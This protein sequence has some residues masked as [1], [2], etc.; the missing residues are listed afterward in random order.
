MSSELTLWTRG[1]SDLGE[2]ARAY[3]SH[4]AAEDLSTVDDDER[5]AR[6]EAHLQLSSDRTGEQPAVRVAEVDGRSIAMVVTEDM[7]HLV[8]SVSGEVSRQGHAMSMVVHPIFLIG[9]SAEEERRL[10]SV[11]RVAADQR[12]LASGD[13]QTMPDLAELLE[14]EHRTVVE[15]WIAVELDHPID[16]EQ[17]GS[18][19]EGLHAVLADVAVS[20][21]D[22]DR[23]RSRARGT[24]GN[25]RETE[26]L[27]EGPEA[28]DL[29][30]WMSD[31]HFLFLG[32][33]EYQFDVPGDPTSQLS[34]VTAGGLGILAPGRDDHLTRLHD[35][36]GDHLGSDSLDDDR[37]PMAITKA[38]AHSTVRRRT[39]MDYVAVKT[40]SS[41]GSVRG[42]R[43]FVGLFNE[44][45]YTQ[46]I[47][48]IPLLRSRAHELLRRSGFT[49]DSHSGS[50]LMQILETYPRDEL[51]QMG[52]DEIEAAA[53]QVL[54]LQERRRIRLILRRD[55][56]G[57]F[58]TALLYMPRDRY[59]TAVRR[60]VEDTLMRHID[61]ESI[62]F[63]VRLTESVLARVFF[64]MRL[65]EG[66]GEPE[67]THEELE[68]RL[69]D[70]I[71][72]WPD[73]VAGQ[74]EARYEESRAPQVAARW[75]EA[76]PA[77]YRVIYELDEAMDDIAEFESLLGEPQAGP[78][79]RFCSPGAD[80]GADMRLKLYL[81]EPKTLT[82]TLPVLDAFGL[83][84]LDERSYTLTLGG[85]EGSLHLYDLGL[86]YPE[87]VDAE[88]T[89]PL[90][91]EAY[92]AVLAGRAESDIFSSLVLHLGL[93][94]RK[95]TVLRA[96][97]G[98]MRQLGITHSY[99][100]I[101]EALRQNAPVASALVEYF[102]ARFD[103]KPDGEPIDEEDRDRRM[104]EARD[105][106]ESAMESVRTL[107]ADRVLSLY[108]NLIDSTQRTNAY[109][110]RPWLA[111]K[112]TPPT[113]DA[114]P[115]P[116]P[117]HEIYVYS[118]QVEGV[119]LR[120][121]K[122]ARGGLRWSDRPED[123]RTE[124][125]GLVK[126]QMVKNSVIVPSG[127]K[128]GFFAKQLP[129]P[130]ADRGAWF[131]AGR[132]AYKVFIRALLD[133]TDNQQERDGEMVVT[134]PDDVIRH[135]GDDPY[136]VVAA[137]KGTATFSDTANEL[138][139]E[140][141][142]WLGDAFASG[143]SVGYDHKAMGITARGAWESV[144]SHFSELGIDC[145]S[146]EFT[147]VAVGDMAGDV[148][149]NGMLRSEHTLLVGAFNH[150]HIFVDPNPDAAASFEERS[151][152]FAADQSGWDAYDTSLISEGGGVFS[153]SDKTVRVTPQMRE[154]FDIDGSVSSMT[155][156]EL[157][158]AMLRAPSD[159]LYNGGIGTY[160]KGS[161]ETHESVGDRA[162]NAVRVDGRDVRAR[163]I[164]E[165][166]NLGM[167]Q[168][169]RIEAAQA[170]TLLNT[171]AIDN[172]AGV[173]C[174]D[175]EVN[176]KILVDQLI[177]SGHFDADDRAQLLRDMTDDVAE[178]V[179]RNNRDQNVLLLTDRHRMGDWSPSFQRLMVWLEEVA[180]LDRRL[181]VLPDD[182]DLEARR[183]AEQPL[184]A[185]ELAVLVA[186]AKIQL[187]QQL[188]SSDLPDDPWFHG[189]L[190]A[191]FPDQLSERFAEELGRHPLQ[192]EI[193][194][195]AAANDVINMGGA[196]F[197]FR[198][199]EE[200]F[201]SEAQV[202]RA[203]LIVREIF[204]LE[205]FDQRMRELPVS[206]PREKWALVY[207]DMRRLLDRAVR[208]VLNHGMSAESIAEDVEELAQHVRPL[209]RTLSDRLVG[210]DQER[211][212]IARSKAVADGMP[213]DLA[214]WVSEMFEAFTLLDVADLARSLEMDSEDVADVYYAIYREFSADAMLQRITMLPRKDKW[215][216]LA[217]GAL[218]DELYHALRE[219]SESVLVSTESGAAEDRLAQ[220]REAN[221][222][223]ITRTERLAAEVDEL[224]TDNIASLTVLMRH[225][226]GL[227]GV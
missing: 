137:D 224:T 44:Q 218:R 26:D 188:V 87:G 30:E 120:F 57:R 195:N 60:R 216:A 90:L 67:I 107:D 46:S 201:A 135:D 19:V 183:E 221:A 177:A 113:I 223:K 63:T 86:R 47:T 164:G 37:R 49:Q 129:D 48:T 76:F 167:T 111:L 96:Y 118:P 191:Y 151:R 180:G 203:F 166:G 95:V 69:A 108:L 29:L 196:T 193:I 199:M 103:P 215:Q 66:A 56:Y 163:V 220:W 72:S 154:R 112:L 81:T 175:H 7:P 184:T 14:D 55:P 219:I 157:I 189:T 21:R 133:I 24:A 212:E 194:A 104:T 43:R 127:A 132:E 124:V 6:V 98:Y 158:N 5:L 227:I 28:A 211:V 39:Y 206:F 40:Y 185:P 165:G 217:R 41:D 92:G 145:Q 15:S 33:R 192:R 54:Q 85:S 174:S 109:H 84:I 4:I 171:D 172:S 101:A 214:A 140:Y 27:V 106:V 119:H 77:D 51:L 204:G 89:I 210:T 205:R 168:A 16:D 186:Y 198:A 3:F 61:A 131:E 178:L 170:G 187:K 142:H 83:S 93:N 149:G 207:L 20:H 225:L 173:D 159:L 179:L 9:R 88:S 156:P 121:A 58:M 181:E 125:L 110:R 148:F 116:R 75:Q 70:T 78:R 23:M 190:E 143:G 150:Q 68:R 147:A 45:A 64:R 209:Y 136:L 32:F 169:G 117:A 71:R 34:P 65:K 2:V 12:G 73:A 97:A 50:D 25:L 35:L 182:T 162:N 13:T 91:G 161:D 122:V 114:A 62:E 123:F 59:N 222:D 138:S 52:I 130:A 144:K 42:E 105:A 100:F 176:I 1:D 18:L 53:W 208:W 160:V 8:D 126:A 226:R 36:P 197:V 213:D 115:L 155:P 80:D 141:G 99:D 200:T 139:L 10:L 146:E 102:E 82:D 17:A 11:R 152:L 134:P 74:I 22:Q 79:M 153:R 94:S 128:G 202:V 38:D 31:E